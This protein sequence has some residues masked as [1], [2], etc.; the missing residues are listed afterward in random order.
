MKIVND[1]YGIRWY[2]DEGRL[3]NPDG[4]AYITS[5]GT[6]KY[7]IHGQ[8]SRAGG[9]AVEYVGGVTEWYYKDVAHRIGG[10]AVES[11]H[12]SFSYIEDGLRHRLD[13]PACSFNGH[14]RYYIRGV[15]YTEED[16]KRAS[17]PRVRVRFV[18][19]DMVICSR[20]SQ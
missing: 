1:V 9:P 10:P 16:F 2:D 7:Y 11:P 15:R 8:L 13:G 20:G 17:K 3:H 6:R 12:G 14:E 18:G 19:D 5:Q 4:P